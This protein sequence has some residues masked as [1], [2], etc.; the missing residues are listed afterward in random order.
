MSCRLDRALPVNNIILD[1]AQSPKDL[2]DEAFA[3]A[4]ASIVDAFARTER[5]DEFA[6]RRRHVVSP[7]SSI[8]AGL[9]SRH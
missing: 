6:P 4:Y 5:S 9:P 7:R 8:E 3:D 2:R 1:T